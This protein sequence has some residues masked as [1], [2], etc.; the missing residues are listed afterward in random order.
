MI[1]RKGAFVSSRGGGGNPASQTFMTVRRN[2]AIGD[3]LCATIVADRLIDMGYE[4]SF[5]CH[6]MIHC[7]IRLH[8]KI[9]Q[10][11]EPGGF[12]DVNLDNA[13]ESDPARRVKHFHTMF[14]ERANEQLVRQGI[15]IGAPFNCKPRL[16]VP[17]H[18]KEAVRSSFQNFPRPWVMVCPRSDTYNVRTVQDGTWSEAAALMVGTKFWLGRYPAPP[19]FIDLKAQH[20]DHVIRWLSVC[21]L[22]VTVDTGPMHVAAALGIPVVAISQSS[23]P[24]LHLSDQCDFIGIAPKLDCLNCQLNV[25]PKNPHLPPCQQVEPDFIAHWANAKL[26]VLSHNDVSVVIPIYRP[27]AER[28]NRCIEAVLPQ[29]QEVVVTRDMAGAVPEGALR[30]P[31]VRYVHHSQRDIGYGR[32]VNFGARH[33]CGKWLWLLNDDCYVK[34]DCL[35]RLLECVKPDTGLV[36]HLLRYPDGRIQHGG[37]FR[38]PGMRGWGHIDQ[39]N[40]DCTTKEPREMEN[41]TGASILVRRQA[42]YEIN[43]NDEDF[44]FYAVDDA[45]CLSLRQAGYKI[46]FT[47][48]AEAIHEE[49]ATSRGDPRIGQWVNQGNATFDRKWRWWID[50]NINTVPGKF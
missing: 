48:H 30:H 9:S 43:G 50:Q 46:M 38:N 35:H 36:G 24:D 4:V 29:V 42:F 21:D 17:F 25:C 39:G 15:A 16:H 45:M 27:S 14:F 10:V 11:V 12:C 31:K 7:V 22:L 6:P 47:P 34:P 2:A 8:P 40:R 3:A 28:L 37:K 5:Q 49:A 41:V 19:N 44:F 23:S 13:Y 20:F 1:Q 26:R 33:T 18:D 32:N